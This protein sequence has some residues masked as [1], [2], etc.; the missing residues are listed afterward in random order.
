MVTICIQ[1]K[2]SSVVNWVTEAKHKDAHKAVTQSEVAL[3]ML[4]QKKLHMY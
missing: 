3:H 1:P 4:R 2:Y